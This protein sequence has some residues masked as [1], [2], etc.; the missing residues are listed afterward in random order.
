[1]SKA[2]AN[3]LGSEQHARRW[4]F[5]AVAAVLVLIVLIGG[6][7]WWA[8]DESRAICEIEVTSVDI[9]ERGQVTLSYNSTSRQFTTEYLVLDDMVIP[10]GYSGSS[11]PWERSRGSSE[12][13][14][15]VNE[16]HLDLE[17]RT[18]RER[19]LVRKGQLYRFAENQPLYL[20]DFH[21]EG[22]HRRGYIMFKR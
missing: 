13:L 9:D 11:I 16:S 6:T 7:A 19:V 12:V 4:L 21:E 20:Y 14:F 22:T 5:V 18:L 2:D 10:S 3:S 8:T 15:H 17:S 1:M